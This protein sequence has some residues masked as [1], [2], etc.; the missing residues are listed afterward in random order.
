MSKS[1]IFHYLRFAA[2]VALDSEDKYKVRKACVGAI[3]FR[4]DG[5][6]V[7]ASNGGD[8]KNPNTGAH[9][10]TRLIRKID[11]GAPVIYVARVLR[12][13]FTLGL[14]RPC[15]TCLPRL[16]AIKIGMVIYSVNDHEYGVIDFRLKRKEYE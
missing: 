16:K 13:D 9:A 6:I 11:K 15:V 1:D 12:N 4:T 7:H 5:V 3:G 8:Q 2:Q 14:A 10:E